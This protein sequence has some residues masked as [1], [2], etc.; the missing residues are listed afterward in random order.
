L[1]EREGSRERNRNSG[2]KKRFARFSMKTETKSGK[3][4]ARLR[5]KMMGS[6]DLSI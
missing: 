5:E 6:V 2:R 4:K 1:R 3:A